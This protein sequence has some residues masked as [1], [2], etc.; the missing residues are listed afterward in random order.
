MKSFLHLDFESRSTQELHGS[1]SVGLYNYWLHPD[2]KPLMLAY[3][4]GNGET[5]LWEIVKQKNIPKDLEEGLFDLDRPLMAWNSSFERY[6]LKFGLEIETAI[7][8]WSDPQA[9][10]R[11]LSLPGALDKVG[12]ILALAPEFK[13]D[14]R[15]EDLIKLF[16][17]PRVI[18]KKKIEGQ[19]SLFDGELGLNFNDWNSHPVEWQ[20]FCEYCKKDVIAE[21]EIMRKEMLLRVFPLPELERKIWVFDQKVN[22]RGMPVD[23]DFVKNM[24]ALGTRSK[25]EAVE[26]QNK[27]TGLE[28]ANSPK[29]MLVWVQKQGYEPNTL[30]KD[31]VE[32]WIK[33]HSDKLTPICVDALKARRAASSTTYTK[34]ATVLRQVSADG[35]LRQAFLYMGSARCGRWSSGAAQLHN[36]ARPGILNDY[37]FEDEEVVS[38]ARAMVNKMDYE[39]IQQKYGSVL[40]VIKNLIRTIFSVERL[41]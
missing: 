33:Y 31:T 41:R 10:A 26:R 13:K 30:R 18:R 34:L 36:L 14:G 11:Y 9:S 37:N 38:E 7:E 2:T 24:Y 16:S 32:S 5:K 12:N 20:E 40:L 22:D 39:G 17:E 19:G 4:F 35:R 28:N 27:L 25:K 23:V 6:G 15:G 29:Q 8:R 3:A 21:R 1:E